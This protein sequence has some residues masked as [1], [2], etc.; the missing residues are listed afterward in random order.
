MRLWL[1]GEEL[2]V[3]E[4]LDLAAL[5]AERG[6]PTSPAEGV[7]W[8]GR[9]VPRAELAACRLRAGDRVEVVELMSGG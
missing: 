9:R 2:E 5:L 7:L 6:L 4:G 1:D 8:N 3:R